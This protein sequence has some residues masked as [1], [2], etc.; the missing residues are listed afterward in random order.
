MY[1]YGDPSAAPHETKRRYRSEERWPGRAGH[2]LSDWSFVF[3]FSDWSFPFFFFSF[4]F[5]L[6]GINYSNVLLQLC[7]EQLRHFVED[8]DQNLK[9]LGLVGLVSLMKSHPRVVSE[10]R[11]L[12]W[13]L[14]L[15]FGIGIV[16]VIV[17]II[18]SSFSLYSLRHSHSIVTSLSSFLSFFLCDSH[19]SSD[20]SRCLLI[21]VV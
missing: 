15:L 1:F 13:F 21:D 7:S 8:P 17:V 11:D 2:M 18:L 20:L 5:F 16:I 12:G 9:Y 3:L 14:L 4:F 10:Q 19:L 6:L